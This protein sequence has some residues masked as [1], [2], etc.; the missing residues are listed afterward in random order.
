MDSDNYGH[1]AKRTIHAGLGFVCSMSRSARQ[2][3]FAC[4]R[5]CV[6]MLED[7]VRHTLSVGM[8]KNSPDAR[9]REREREREGGFSCL[10]LPLPR[11][12]GQSLA[13]NFRSQLTSEG[14][15]QFARLVPTNFGQVS[16]SRTCDASETTH[17]V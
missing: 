10:S 13:S 15:G 5:T 7:N 3:V 9:E 12:S 6:F 1:A 16:R 8:R 14:G 17:R 2:Y 4:L 11:L